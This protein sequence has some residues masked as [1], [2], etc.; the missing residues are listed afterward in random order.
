MKFR[1]PVIGFVIVLVTAMGA[2]L[3]TSMLRAQDLIIDLS[4]PV[5]AITAGFSG[6]D[7]LLFGTTRGGEGD[8]VVVVRGPEESPVVRRKANVNGIWI[9]DDNVVF[10]Y[11]PSFY[12]L[13]SNRPILNFVPDD[14]A[15]IH[16]IGTEQILFAP[17]DNTLSASDLEKFSDAVIR[18]KQT[19]GLYSTEEIDLIYL[20]NGL[21]RTL[22]HFPANVTVGTYGIDVYLF[23]N[24]ELIDNQTTLLNVRKF[25]LEAEIFNFAH[26][27]SAL[28][29]VLAV[30]IAAFAGWLANV[31]FRKG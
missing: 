15:S 30:L 12:A 3:T 19:E 24:G 2:I 14:V 20:G 1:R 7:L 5:V 4:T 16:Q 26:R 18:I 17:Q 25:G 6:T 28:Y 29:G 9:N 10:D 21:F 11:V 8:L 13:A 31:A 23:K 27:Y 22:V